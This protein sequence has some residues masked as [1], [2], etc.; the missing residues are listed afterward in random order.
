MTSLI[1]APQ[2]VGEVDPKAVGLDE[3]FDQKPFRPA[4]AELIRVLER[5]NRV[6]R[7]EFFSGKAQ[8]LFRHRFDV[9]SAR[10]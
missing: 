7:S 8:R 6:D 5:M 10:K 1:L 3:D 4:A 9:P 2:V